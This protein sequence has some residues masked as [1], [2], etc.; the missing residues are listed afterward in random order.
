MYKD[1]MLS[2]SINAMAVKQHEKTHLHPQGVMK[3]GDEGKLTI[4]GIG[5]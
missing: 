1:C 2:N 4:G 3:H 5:N